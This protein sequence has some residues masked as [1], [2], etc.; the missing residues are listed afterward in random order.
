MIDRGLIKARNFTR[1]TNKLGYAYM[2]TPAG[3]TEKTA[4]TSLFLK[5]KVAEYQAL[6]AEIEILTTE[7][8][9]AARRVTHRN[10][11]GV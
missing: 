4:L 8:D 10:D 11:P 7:L 5:R 3:L 1:S 9:V 2:L 6:K